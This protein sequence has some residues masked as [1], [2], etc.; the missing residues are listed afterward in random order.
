M[1]DD[2]ELQPWSRKPDAC[3]HPIAQQYQMLG[4]RGALHWMCGVC[5][6]CVTYAHPKARSVPLPGDDTSKHHG[7]CRC[8]LCVLRYGRGSETDRQRARYEEK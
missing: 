6:S 7:D 3:P 8:N 5:M 2:T 1:P 4:D